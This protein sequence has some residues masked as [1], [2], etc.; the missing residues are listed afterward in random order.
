MKK[1]HYILIIGLLT[2]NYVFSQELELFP[3]HNLKK[4]IDVIYYPF[5]NGLQMIEI[6]NYSKYSFHQMQYF[7]KGYV[8]P[9]HGKKVNEY[10]FRD[11]M[12]LII[13]SFN[14][15]CDHDSISK[16]FN[17]V[18]FVNRNNHSTTLWN[19][20]YQIGKLSGYYDVYENSNQGIIDSLGN[21][22]IPIT[23]KAI[24]HKPNCFLVN[25]DK[26]WRL[27][28]INNFQLHAGSFDDYHERNPLIFF[29]IKNKLAFLYNYQTGMKNDL[30]IWDDIKMLA[31]GYEGLVWVKKNDK[32]GLWNYNNNT[33]VLSFDYDSGSY[34]SYFF[35]KEDQKV[36]IVS[37]NGKYGLIS[38]AFNQP[39]MI[40]KCEYDKIYG[41]KEKAG[42]P[43]FF[44][45]GYI[46]TEKNGH[47]LE[48]EINE[49]LLA[50]TKIN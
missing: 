29:T 4:D 31:Q 21:I 26:K 14:T 38:L 43:Y 42:P 1:V 37:K 32:W 49:L 23:Y 13:K 2:A 36:I 3:R 35:S 18:G 30:S 24:I 5:R 8:P 9:Y 17:P 6:D 27:I 44:K 22:V 45:T 7:D 47:K 11:T 15:N 16:V 20:Y 10:F 46:T 48:Y 50:K 41:S 39:M 28:T 34:F 25:K 12:G 40:L 19:D 33:Q